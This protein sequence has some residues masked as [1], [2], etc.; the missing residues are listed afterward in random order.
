MD[1]H[2]EY[3]FSLNCLSEVCRPSLLTSSCRRCRLSCIPVLFLAFAE[4]AVYKMPLLREAERERKV[5]A[6]GADCVAA[7]KTCLLLPP[8]H[9][10]PLPASALLQHSRHQTAHLRGSGHVPQGLYSSWAGATRW[11]PGSIWTVSA[12]CPDSTTMHRPA[13]CVGGRTPTAG[14]KQETRDPHPLPEQ[15]L[16]LRLA[17]AGAA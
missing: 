1:T 17:L 3:R 15:L 6:R 10:L 14:A 2:P 5:Q 7:A 11:T 12:L 16:Q 4:Q 8:P 9:V 13:S